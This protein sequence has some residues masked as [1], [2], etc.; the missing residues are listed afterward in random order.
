MNKSTFP[1][2]KKGNDYSFPCENR[3]VVP[4]LA[5]KS[6]LKTENRFRA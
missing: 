6:N 1:P 4:A 5:E 3:P 2:M